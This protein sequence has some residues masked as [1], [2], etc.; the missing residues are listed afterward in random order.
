MF[1]IGLACLLAL[2]LWGVSARNASAF[3]EAPVLNKSSV[4]WVEMLHTH[5]EAKVRRA[6]LIALEAFGPKN[7]TA[8]Q[9]LLA[10]LEKEPEADIRK[11]I[12]QLLGRHGKDIKD[13]APAALATALK[14]DK[15]E[16]VR[17]AAA[18]VLGNKFPEQ[19]GEY[20]PQLAEALKDKHAGTRAA[21]AESLKVAGDAAKPAVP[22][23][24]V[25]ARDKN[26][27]KFC[28]L[29]ALQIV[30]RQGKDTPDATKALV[31]ILAD[32]EALAVIREAAAEGLG[33]LGNPAS[34][35][36]LALALQDKESK[37]RIAAA[38]SLGQLGAKAKE[39]WPAIVA[40]LKSDD[41]ALRY[42][43]VRTMAALAKE[44]TEALVELAKLAENDGSP[45]IRIAAIQEL[46]QLGPFARDQEPVLARLVND[47]RASVREAAGFALKKV[48][49][50]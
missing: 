27:E 44:K 11:E 18:S 23:L 16:L 42:Q 7:R 26:E 29:Y 8:V 41:T 17:E 12:V 28:R 36:A 49:G 39:A 47:P 3:G 46:G 38:V 30:S 43:L 1:R 25:V 40:N 13:S 4:Q 31:E 21:A 50:L 22:A 9:G 2:T 35:P 48:K 33:R 19:T 24:L 32:A 20:V 10:A 6:S 45:E 14:S 5:K 34:V 15:S 37:V